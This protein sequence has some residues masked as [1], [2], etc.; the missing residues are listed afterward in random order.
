NELNET[1]QA[2]LTAQLEEIDFAELEKLIREYVLVKPKTAIPDDLGPAP[3]VRALARKAGANIYC[4]R[5]AGIHKGRDFVAITANQPGLYDLNVGG[6]AEWFD[7][8]TGK[9]LGF[10][11]QLKLNLKWAETVVACKKNMLDK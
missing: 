4:S 9:S 2:E 1:E 10:G 11:P 7:A 8:D 3:V 6:S 5:D